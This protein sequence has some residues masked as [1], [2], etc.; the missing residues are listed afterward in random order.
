MYEI[1]TTKHFEKDLKRLYKTGKDLTELKETMKIL[2]QSKSFDKKYRLHKL[3]GT[4]GNI[5][6]Y[7]LAGDWL[8]LYRID[9]KTNSIIFIRT[10]THVQVGLFK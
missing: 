4:Y 8:V 7:H 9:E 5:M 6:E 3:K 2:S 10:G 1:I